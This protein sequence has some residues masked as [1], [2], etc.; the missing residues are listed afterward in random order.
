MPPW[1]EGAIVMRSLYRRSFARLAATLGVMIAAS[2]LLGSTACVAQNAGATDI[3]TVRL[4]ASLPT[5]TNAVPLTMLADHFDKAHGIA[6]DMTWAG[7]SSSLMVEAVLSGDV[8]F[9]AP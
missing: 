4:I 1:S 7:G 9:G 5:L 8:E 3:R 2:G 6:V